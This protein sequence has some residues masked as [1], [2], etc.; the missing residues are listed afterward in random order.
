VRIL[1]VEDEHRLADRLARGL[2]EEGLAVD[3]A[4]TMALARELASGADYD[5]VLL[6]LKLPD[7]S[8]LELLA[9]WRENG[10]TAP[11]LVLTAKDL[12][13]DK[14]RGLKA[15]ADDYL[16]KPFSF[17]E[18]LARIQALLRRCAAPPRSILEMGDLRLDRSGH[19]A[20]RAGRAIELT[21]KEFALLEFLALHVGQVMSRATIAEHVWDNGYD[22]QS[23]VIDVIVSRLRRK[24]EAGGASRLLHTVGGV[25]YTM[26]QS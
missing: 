11:I 16:T 23:N 4:R 7:G 24:L 14:V 5:L 3:L 21:A 13:E 10:F 2:R 20:E 8:G 17:A 26:R 25:G 15:G 19:R 22:A 18:L 1:V 6:D 12:L 9:E